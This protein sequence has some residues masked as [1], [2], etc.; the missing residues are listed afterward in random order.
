[1]RRV[2]RGLTLVRRDFLKIESLLKENCK[3]YMFDIDGQVL[4]SFEDAAVAKEVDAFSKITI[5]TYDPSF[6]IDISKRSVLVSTFYD[7]VRGAGV[8]H[9]LTEH[10]DTRRGWFS[11][12]RDEFYQKILNSTVWVT[13]II[14][15]FINELVGSLSS[16]S[17]ISI[18]LGFFGPAIILLVFGWVFLRNTINVLENKP[19]RKALG[20]LISGMII[21]LFSTVVSIGFE[22]LVTAYPNLGQQV[23]MLFHKVGL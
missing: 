11:V 14:I 19:E 18:N 1:M 22:H 12:F 17:Y 20:S 23:A 21:A 7:N 4:T 10:L 8:F 16:A 5:E 13:L 2:Y 6:T 15:L 3:R 9:K